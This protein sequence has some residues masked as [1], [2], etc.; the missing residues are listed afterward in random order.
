MALL[1][2]HVKKKLP[3]NLVWVFERIY[4]FDC[5]FSTGAWEEDYKR[6]IGKIITEHKQLYDDSS[7]MILDFRERDQENKISST[8]EGLE[9]I[10]IIAYPR[11][12]EGCPLLSLEVIHH[13]L[14]STETWLSVAQQNILIMHSELGGWP[15][16]AF[17]AAALSL[18]RKYFTVETKALEVVYKQAPNDHVLSKLSPMNPMPSQLRYLQ[19]VSKR[20]ADSEWPPADKALTLDCVIMRM[21]PDFDGK[22]GCCPVF[23]I[24]GRDP[25]YP[26]LLYSTPRRKKNIR[27]YN[28][29]DS[30]LV[31][32]D[33]NCHIQGDVVLECISLLDDMTKEKIMYRAMFNTAFI[34]S[35]MLML[36]RDEIDMHW[37]AKD[38]FHKDFKAELLFSE[39]DPL[40]SL[41][42]ADPSCFEEEE[43]PGEAF[44]KVQDMFGSVDWLVP[45]SD[46]TLSRLH[47]M[48]LS[49]IVTEMMVTSFQGTESKNL[50]HTPTKRNNNQ[51]KETNLDAVG[52]TR[53]ISLS[54][55]LPAST[56]T[57]VDASKNSLSL[58]SSVPP[59]II[60]TC[61]HPSLTEKLRE[62]AASSSAPAIL[63]SDGKGGP[64][65]PTPPPLDQTKPLLWSKK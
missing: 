10:T 16:L 62:S 12:Y 49:D 5:C 41:V 57:S 65:P 19:Y 25:L 34:K 6:Y 47:Q 13:F 21:I 60:L 53:S 44:S 15:V 30:E 35:N 48:P 56:Q 27:Y 50:L 63:P 1:R 20:N 17:M 38:Q 36:N 3:D 37:D 54:R 39:M 14:K 64:R 52:V 8:L 28:Q 42:P 11:H 24:Y 9:Y 31:K 32:I 26:K 2:K 46:D 23:R 45:K 33:I 18:Y 43:L 55:Q 29:A 40:A 22:G 59:H 4:V 51:D 61:A 58:S 7:I